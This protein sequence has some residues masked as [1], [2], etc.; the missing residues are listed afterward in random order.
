MILNKII[1]VRL[2]IDNINDMFCSNYNDMIFKQLTERYVN[3]CFRS[4]YILEILRIIK[5]SKL[6]CKDKKL[7]GNT[8]IDILFEVQGIIYEKNEIIHDCEIIQINNNGIIHAKS[9]YA[10][11]QIKNNTGYDIFKPDEKIPVIINTV[12]YNLFQGD[13]SVSANPLIPVDKEIAYYRIIEKDNNEH[14]QLNVIKLMDAVKVLENFIKKINKTN[15]GEKIINF[16]VK[17]LLY[18]YKKYQDY[19][20]LY[21]C[22]K[23]KIEITS[24]ESLNNGDVIFRPSLYLTDDTFYY[25]SADNLSN[26]INENKVILNITYYD[27]INHIIYDYMKDLLCLKGFLENYT[28]LS[29]IKKYSNIW[30][31]YTRLKL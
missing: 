16:F 7:D 13:I 3:K 17:N 19:K 29:H 10:S 23:S 4:I 8:Y 27:A 5:R 6:T 18:P 14:N 20:K 15:E 30:Q 21:N 9:K 31:M 12:R 2:N 24:F 25:Q 26:I 1:E 28:S 22:Q 11:L